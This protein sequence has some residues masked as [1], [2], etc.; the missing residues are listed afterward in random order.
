MTS[1]AVLALNDLRAREEPQFVERD[2]DAIKR[3]LVAKFE[4]V[5]GRTLYP[6]QVEMFVIEVMAFAISGIGAAIQGG[7]LQNRTV[8]AQGRHLDDLGANVG[9]QRLAAQA[10]RARVVFTLSEIRQTAVIVPVG[11]RVAAGPDL[12]FATVLELIIPAGT[13]TGTVDVVAASVGA[14][15]N[16]LA[17]GVIEDILDPVAYVESVSNDQVTSGGANIEG[18][19]RFRERIAGS[20]ERISRGGSRQGYIELVKAAHPDIVDV[21]VVRPQPGFI[22]ITPLVSDGVAGASVKAAV[23]DYLD[24][25]V[26]M[27]D[28]VSI[29]DADR[30]SFTTTLLLRV[31]PG[32][33]N[34]ARV[35]AET[36]IRTLFDALSRILGAQVAPS[37][38]VEAVRQ[39]VAPLG[40]VGVDGPGFE[41]TDLPGTSFA[42]LD[43]IVIDVE[44]TPNV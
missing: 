25:N 44:E 34:L 36:A 29:R 6:A 9:I 41:F 23:L 24:G 20:F 5:S 13:T 28:F 10:A 43:A 21:Q 14:V 32:S 1:L 37:A 7:L 33:G 22:E 15:Y 17:L 30:V 38:V 16:D 31:K 26:P 12:V 18:D 3:S 2:T 27:G 42:A 8:W 4:E 19:D 39:A 35:G 40:V 11:T